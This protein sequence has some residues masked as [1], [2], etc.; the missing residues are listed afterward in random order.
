MAIENILHHYKQSAHNL[1]SN[2]CNTSVCHIHVRRNSLHWS[3][4]DQAKP[5]QSG[6]SKICEWDPI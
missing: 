2:Q 6:R 4:F 3:I 5:L 1:L